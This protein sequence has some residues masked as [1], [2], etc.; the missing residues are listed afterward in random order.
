MM[1]PGCGWPPAEMPVDHPAETS[2]LG[3]R[4]PWEIEAAIT[5]SIEPPAAKPALPP[6]V[7]KLPGS[8]S[9]PVSTPAMP[10]LCG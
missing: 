4:R 6:L 5:W 1:L 9:R 8:S 10:R 7:L 2:R 3:N